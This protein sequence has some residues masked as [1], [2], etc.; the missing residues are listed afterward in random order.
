MSPIGKYRSRSP[1]DWVKHLQAPE[2][3][4]D[5]E[6]VEYVRERAR[7]EVAARPKNKWLYSEDRSDFLH[8]MAANWPTLHAFRQAGYADVALFSSFFFDF[9]D[10]GYVP[11]H[12]REVYEVYKSGYGKPLVNVTYPRQSGKT[13]ALVKVPAWHGACYF[14]FWGW[15]SNKSKQMTGH[16]FIIIGSETRDQALD[17]LAH[18]KLEFE[19]NELL[20]AAFA[21]PAQES[22]KPPGRQHAWNINNIILTNYS[23]IL[24]LGRLSQT[25]GKLHLSFRPTLFLLDDLEGNTKVTN[26]RIL[27]DT[28][29]WLFTEVLPARHMSAN[30]NGR[31]Y[32]YGNVVHEHCLVNH[33][34]RKSDMF[35]TMYRQALEPDADGELTSIWPE[36]RPTNLLVREREEYSKEG[37]LAEWLQENMNEAMVRAERPF[38]SE[39]LMFYEAEYG[40]SARDHLGYLAIDRVY[41]EQ[42]GR[43]YWNRTNPVCTYLGVDVAAGEESA[44]DYNVVLVIAVDHREDVYVLDYWHKKTGSISEVRDQIFRL[45]GKY[46]VRA[47]TIEVIG[48]QRWMYNEVRKRQRELGQWFKLIPEKHSSQMSKQER[49]AILLEPRFDSGALRLRK[50]MLELQT[51]LQQFP[52]G[53][54]DDIVDALW[55]ALAYAR[56][57]PNRSLQIDQE[58][59]TLTER[60]LPV[61][62]PVN[63]LTVA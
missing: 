8:R 59:D 55:L 7:D 27:Q 4:K 14:N 46:N 60:A 39:K 41:N 62:R 9:I 35:H 26:I 16:P 40:W 10:N 17:V 36:R 22:L 20:N 61:E 53:E 24:A 11:E 6:A 38:G 49:C 21:P 57:A 51:E 33:L 31:V 42:R 30:Y 28:R 23:R 32:V 54:H 29:T 44:S 37:R 63:P 25:R 50:D 52:Q 58:F 2:N 56:P 47:C 13:T 15:R 18:I 48:T 43:I 5:F 45:A 1:S 3:H 19:F 34:R 12:H